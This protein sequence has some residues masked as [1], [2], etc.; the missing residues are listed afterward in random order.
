MSLFFK[1]SYLHTCFIFIIFDVRNLIIFK[2]SIFTYL[3]PENLGYIKTDLLLVYNS[4]W[5]IFYIVSFFIF[6][7]LYMYSIFI[8]LYS[9]SLRK[10]VTQ[11]GYPEDHDQTKW[12][13][14]DYIKWITN[15]TGG[16]KKKPEEEEN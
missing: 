9:E 3:K 6:I 14:T 12:T 8:S 16:T 1:N 10:N 15:I 5:T 2:K 11:N 4:W 13:L 7:V